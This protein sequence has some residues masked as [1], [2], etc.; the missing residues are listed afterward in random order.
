MQKELTR[1]LGVIR[2][3]TGICVTALSTDKTVEA[4]S[5]KDYFGVDFNKDFKTETFIDKENCLTYFKFEYS[6]LKFLGAIKGADEVSK[7]YATFISE[8]IERS[9][10]KTEILG[11]DEQ[12]LQIIT[13]EST[14]TR[15]LNFMQKYSVK[16]GE[17][18]CSVFKSEEKR[19]EE[20]CEFLCDYSL[21]GKD[22]AVVIDDSTVAFLKFAETEYL[23][24]YT[25]TDE[26]IKYIVR[27]LYE[28]LGIRIKVFVGGSVNGLAEASKSYRQALETERYCK[29]FSAE[30][31]V[32]SYKDFVLFK[33]AEELPSNKILELYTALNGKNA[34]EVLN[35]FELTE[36]A[37]AL[38]KNGLNLSETAR[39]MHLHRNTLIYRLDKIQKI[40]GLNLREFS[41]ALSFRLLTVFYKLIK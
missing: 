36:T 29:V 20:I 27:S 3:K 40:T 8:Y 9:E 7:N 5:F 12:F 32:N 38:F 35:D 14:K 4:S 21:N 33:M 15:T 17:C 41:D 10:P 25:S 31:S 16:D 1:I 23:A 37:D 2:D 6:G 34:E 30:N 26:F 28:E 22:N 18:F 39:V 19:S 11:Y 24:E 13:G